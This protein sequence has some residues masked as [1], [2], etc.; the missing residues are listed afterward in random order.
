[1]GRNFCRIVTFN[2]TFPRKIPEMQL[3]NMT[4]RNSKNTYRVKIN[5]KKKGIIMF[6]Q[7]LACS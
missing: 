6:D 3:L 1:M 7:G 4:R 2:G 5:F